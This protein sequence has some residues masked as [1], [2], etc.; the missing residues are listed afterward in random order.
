[1]SNKF[2][3]IVI[4]KHEQKEKDFRMSVDTKKKRFNELFDYMDY[5][6]RHPRQRRL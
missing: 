4:A 2:T 3:P 1:M 6:H 5:V